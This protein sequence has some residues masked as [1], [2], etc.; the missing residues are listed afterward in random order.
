VLPGGQVYFMSDSYTWTP[1]TSCE[2]APSYSSGYLKPFLGI[3]VPS[4]PADLPSLKGAYIY[5]GYGVGDTTS[6]KGDFCRN[7]LNN[8]TF[9]KSNAIF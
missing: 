6:A 4:P 9:S 2:T 1:F 3:V 8:G 7:M 5:T